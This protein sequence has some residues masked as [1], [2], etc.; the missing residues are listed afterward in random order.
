MQGTIVHYNK[1][2][3]QKE[4]SQ[5]TKRKS[6]LE[7]EEKQLQSLRVVPKISI[8]DVKGE[9]ELKRLNGLRKKKMQKDMDMNNKLKDQAQKQ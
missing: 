6:L 1:L 4:T 3:N 2:I 5:Y 9:E 8:Q 7:A